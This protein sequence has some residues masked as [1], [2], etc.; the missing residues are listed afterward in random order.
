MRAEQNMSVPRRYRHRRDRTPTSPGDDEKG[1]DGRHRPDRA[2]PVRV[3]HQPHTAV[4]DTTGNPIGLDDI[5][6]RG[7]ALPTH[8]HVVAARL[9]WTLTYPDGCYVPSRVSRVVTAQATATLRTLTYRDTA[10]AS[11]SAR[12]DPA[13]G[14]IAPPASGEAYVPPGFARGV[15]RQ[16]VARTRRREEVSS[17][18][19]TDP[20][21]RRAGAVAAVRGHRSRPRR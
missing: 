5:D 8:G 20:D 12:F 4:D 16:L 15:R 18:T 14:H 3:H 21:P 13:T 10:I 11:L 17:G 19:A 1:R 2:T 7:R 6:S 9:G